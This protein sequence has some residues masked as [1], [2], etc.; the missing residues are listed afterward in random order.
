MTDRH[1]YS[2]LLYNT[3]SLY[4]LQQHRQT[5]LKSTKLTSQVCRQENKASWKSINQESVANVMSL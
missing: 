5:D 3:M 1:Q 4:L 2:S